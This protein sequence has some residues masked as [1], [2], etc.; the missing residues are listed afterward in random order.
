MD[1][2]LEEKV[3][4]VSGG[5]SGISLAISERL[6]GEGARSRSLDVNVPSLSMPSRRSIARKVLLPMSATRPR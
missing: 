1:L 3:A 4:L 6:S 5:T 2:G